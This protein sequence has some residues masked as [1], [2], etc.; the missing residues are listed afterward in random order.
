MPMDHQALISRVLDAVDASAYFAPVA[1]LDTSQQ[2]FCASVQRSLSSPGFSAD[3]IRASIHTAHRDGTIDRIRFFSCLQV[4]A[5]HPSV[6]DWAEA[7]QLAAQQELAAM[8]HGGPHLQT[9]L[10]SV[11]RH[12]GVLAFLTGHPEIALDYFTRALERER[13]AENVTNVLCTLLRL[14]DE[15]DAREL[16]DQVCGVFPPALVAEI[17]FNVNNDPDLA[18]LREEE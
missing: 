1:Q 5:C 12:R 7:A 2:A 11:D 6:A 8:E 15:T 9:N 16:Y 4:V 14:G 3:G 18:L 13:S 10:A 17:R